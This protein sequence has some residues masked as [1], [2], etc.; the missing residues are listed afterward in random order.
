MTHRQVAAAAVEWARAHG[1][2][3][4][5]IEAWATDAELERFYADSDG[6]DTARVRDIIAT[7]VG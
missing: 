6:I 1:V 5:A 4:H 3:E 2:E 7:M